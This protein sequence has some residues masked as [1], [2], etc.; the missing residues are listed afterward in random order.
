M[1]K[2][3]RTQYLYSCET[4]PRLYV[5]WAARM[6]YPCTTLVSAISILACHCAHC[7]CS[8]NC[9]RL[10]GH[11][12][13]DCGSTGLRASMWAV[14]A[15]ARFMRLLLPSLRR[16]SRLIVQVR[17]CPRHVGAV[18]SVLAMHKSGPSF[19]ADE[20][21]DCVRLPSSISRV[22]VY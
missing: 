4:I 16:R 21:R 19:A 20:R 6:E 22:V 11:S 1:S 9:M 18:P 7:T 2:R 15:Q 12:L 13:S 17:P 5:L 3:H 8:G 14:L 10:Q